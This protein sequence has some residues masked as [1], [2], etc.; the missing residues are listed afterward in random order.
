MLV[1][2]RAK[3]RKR[4]LEPRL[5]RALRPLVI[6]DEAERQQ[7][8][9]GVE[10][11]PGQPGLCEQL[12]AIGDRLWVVAQLPG[13]AAR[14][15][16]RLPPKPGWRSLADDQSP[17]QPVATLHHMSVHLPKLPEGSGQP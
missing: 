15:I 7:R 5:R 4:L 14:R 2:E 11:I 8:Q 12:L 6:G 13:E 3:Q 10:V 16:E 9:R 17:C 1:S